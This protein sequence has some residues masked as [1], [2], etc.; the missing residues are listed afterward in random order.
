MRGVRINTCANRGRNLE[1]LAEFANNQYRRQGL[2]IVHKVPTE[3]LPLRDRSGRITGAKVQRQAAVD[4]LGVYQGKA[5][6]FDAKQTSERRIRW[7]RV[8]PHQAEF[9]TDWERRGGLSF[10]LVC[11]MGTANRGRYYLVPWSWWRERLEEY[12]RRNSGSRAPASCSA[13]ELTTKWEIPLTA[14]AVV[15]YLAVVDRLMAGEGVA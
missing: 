6:A 2:A 13:D 12:D 5:I 14:R 8:E 15:D 3:W 7:D 11:F 1:L 9:L 4:F 10:I